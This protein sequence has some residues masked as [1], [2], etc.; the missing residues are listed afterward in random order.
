MPVV[1]WCESGDGCMWGC[2]VRVVMGARGDV[3]CEGCDGCLW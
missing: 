1:M 3:W 2:G